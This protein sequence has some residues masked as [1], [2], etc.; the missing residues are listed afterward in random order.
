MK[1]ILSFASL[2]AAAVML[3]S[4]GGE[5]GEEGGSVS[6]KTLKLVSDKNLIQTFGGDY[7]TLTLTLDGEPV[8]EGVTFFDGSNKVIEIPDFKFSSDKVGEFKIW[9]NYGTYNSYPQ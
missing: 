5:N 9:A 2:L 8:T 4:C 6:N 7:A 1:R 3:I